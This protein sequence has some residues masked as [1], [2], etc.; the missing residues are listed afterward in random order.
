MTNRT[1]CSH[2]RGLR[3]GGRLGSPLNQI[4]FV[5]SMGGGERKKRIRPPD[6]IRSIS[7]PIGSREGNE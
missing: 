7:L 2:D 4:R 1:L 3:P 5:P 6:S